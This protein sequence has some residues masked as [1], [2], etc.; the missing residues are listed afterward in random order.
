MADD[1]AD[2]VSGMLMQSSRF[3]KQSILIKPQRHATTLCK[4]QGGIVLLSARKKYEF[5]QNSRCTVQKLREWYCNRDLC[6]HP[7]SVE[8]PVERESSMAN[9]AEPRS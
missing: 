1:V 4:E 3:V 9:T 2:D 7:V 5:V 8:G 6:T